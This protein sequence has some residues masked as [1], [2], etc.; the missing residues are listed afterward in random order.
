MPIKKLF[1]S[2]IITLG[3]FASGLNINYVSKDTITL[4]KQGK[5]KF[6]EIA[7]S[8]VERTKMNVVIRH[9]DGAV[10]NYKVKVDR[11]DKRKSKELLELK[12]NQEQVRIGLRRHRMHKGL[13]TNSKIRIPHT[14]AKKVLKTSLNKDVKHLVRN[15]DRNVHSSDIKTKVRSVKM[16]C[17]K[18]SSKTITCTTF[19][20]VDAK[21]TNQKKT[22]IGLL[23]GHLNDLRK[24]MSSDMGIKYDMDG[25]REFLDK[26]EKL[27]KKSLKNVTSRKIVAR[28]I[29][30][31]QLI[32][33]ERIE[34]YEY[35]AIRAKSIVSFVDKVLKGLGQNS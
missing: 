8:R 15:L 11:D 2:S 20:K 19:S 30:T 17:H 32:I 26:S 3:A 12:L 31:K 28:L 13:V 24:E 34:S 27:I 18:I 7:N 14:V 4:K 16:E 33:D 6:V 35:T 22:N 10:E 1:L 21:V 29:N 25:Y 23:V 9:E 5:S